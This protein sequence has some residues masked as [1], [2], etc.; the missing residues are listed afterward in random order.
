MNNVN[1]FLKWIELDK[2]VEENEDWNAKIKYLPVADCNNI[3]ISNDKKFN[4][5][6]LIE[7]TPY[8]IKDY[9]PKKVNGIKIEI[10]KNDSLDK[11]KLYL[12]LSNVEK[13]LDDTFI[14]FS[15]FIFE[16]LENTTNE[17]DTMRKVEEAL[18]DYHDFFSFKKEMTKDNEQGLIAELNFLSD[19]IDK[20]GEEAVY[21]WVGSE[22]NKRD[23]I[24]NDK[25]VEIK[26]TRNQ[27]QD[28]ISVSNENQLDPQGL[29]TLYLR[30]YIFDENE[31]GRE[32]SYFIKLIADKIKSYEIKKVFFS[33][34]AMHGIDPSAYVGKY[35]F[36]IEGIH[37]YVVDD[38]FPRIKKSN[39]SERIYDVK[40]R[41]NLSGI[42]YLEKRSDSVGGLWLFDYESK[43]R[44]E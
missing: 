37:T 34:I 21:Y 32:V 23:F 3:F 8:I 17:I 2:T 38:G 43:R 40:Y 15:A 22:K 18:I 28:I 10:K 1:Y 19:L 42:D 33:K 11:N 16:R 39:C 30:L 29:T 27:E 31:N 6:F 9:K 36:Y 4:R 13:K 25:A 24:I 20:Y 35:K 12:V 41:L 14:G 5:S 7:F 26:S 44:N